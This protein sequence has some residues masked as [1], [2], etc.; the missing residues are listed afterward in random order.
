[1]VDLQAYSKILKMDLVV[2]LGCTEPIAIALCAAKAR[3]ILG[4][5][6]EFIDVYCSGNIIKNVHSVTVPNSK[7]LKG[8]EIA[9]ALGAFGGDA[10]KGLEVL[11]GLSDED[12]AIASDFANQGNVTVH[13]ENTRE[14]LFIRCV[15]KSI[16]N[17][18]EVV[19]SGR[20]TNI[21]V[22]KKNHIRLHSVPEEMEKSQDSDINLSQLNI[23]DICEFASIVDLD[24]DCDLMDT[25]DRQIAYN[26]NIAST[27]IAESWGNEIGRTLLN[28]NKDVPDVEATAWAAAGSDARM[29]GCALPVV[30]NSGSGN[31]G[32]TVSVPVIITARKHALSKEKLYRALIISNLVNIHE[33]AHIGNLS[34]FCGAVTAAAGAGAGIAYLY[35]MSLD[36]IKMVITNTL[37]ASLGILCDG[38]KPSCASKIHSSLASA[39]LGIE[40]AKRNNVI[41]SGDG[42]IGDSIEKTIDNIGQIACEGMN[43]ADAEILKVII[44]NSRPEN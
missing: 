27:G 20:H 38:A 4:Q 16:K 29:G 23:D 35:D 34:A 12:I 44:E 26:M 25:L 2:A 3:E 31:Q 10:N 13:H 7:G 30:V 39:M 6:P 28:V 21:T 40:M 17:T 14:K 11:T 24:N 32:L 15:L 22:M 36:Q 19:I 41:N 1:M 5:I 9:A 8:V 18:A 43:E 33:K 42:F 37:A